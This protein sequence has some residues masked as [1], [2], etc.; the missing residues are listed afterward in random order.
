MEACFNLKNKK[1]G[2]KEF[3]EYFRSERYDEQLTVDDKL[4]IF[5][6]SL[7]YIPDD[8]ID[9]INELLSDY[10]QDFGACEC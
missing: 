8:F 5:C 9:I 7:A 4:E 3:M 10:D 1:F 2:R 6:Q